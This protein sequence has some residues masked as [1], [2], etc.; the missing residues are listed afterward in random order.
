MG[1]IIKSGRGVLIDLTNC[2]ELTSKEQLSKLPT[3]DPNNDESNPT[4]LMKLLG[5]KL[6][7]E[8]YLMQNVGDDIYFALVKGY[9]VEAGDVSYDQLIDA[10]CYIDNSFTPIKFDDLRDKLEE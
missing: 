7:W 6:P 10:G 3:Y 5:T 1:E 8:W 2:V 4:V 9:V